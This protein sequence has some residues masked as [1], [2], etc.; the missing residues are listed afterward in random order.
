LDGG[1][2]VEF[3]VVGTVMGI[4]EGVP[5]HVIVLEVGEKR[6]RC[7]PEVARIEGGVVRVGGREVRVWIGWCG[8]LLERVESRDGW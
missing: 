4:V 1:D 3:V 7:G 5:C 2:E 6:K 8:I